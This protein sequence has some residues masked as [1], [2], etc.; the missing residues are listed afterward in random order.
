MELD[1]ALF[2]QFKLHTVDAAVVPALLRK[3]YICRPIVNIIVGPAGNSIACLLWRLPYSLPVGVTRCGVNRGLRLGGD[4]TCYHC[5]L[6][7]HIKCVIGPPVVG[8][9]LMTIVPPPRCGC[10]TVAVQGGEEMY[11][12][13]RGRYK[14]TAR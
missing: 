2:F 12:H 13:C 10:T 6:A 11:T 14:G 4:L 8:N 5:E 9:S 3:D 7:G 1:K